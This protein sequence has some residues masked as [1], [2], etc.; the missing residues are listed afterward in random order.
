MC[1][2]I[3]CINTGKFVL[4][5][6]LILSTS[7]CTCIHELL[8]FIIKK[9]TYKILQMTQ[10]TKFLKVNLD[11]MLTLFSSF[12]SYNKYFLIIYWFS[13]LNWG[14][15]N[16]I[17]CS[18]WQIET[19]AKHHLPQMNNQTY[20]VKFCCESSRDLPHIFLFKFR[21]PLKSW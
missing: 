8:S 20:S 6:N 1:L 15:E 11:S 9:G 2:S 7:D 4:I 13:E 5:L 3:F 12:C 16:F 21:L 17:Y 10:T 14:T 18:S 19:Y